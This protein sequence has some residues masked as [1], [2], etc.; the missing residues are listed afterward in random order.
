[1]SAK[2]SVAL[3][4]SL[5][6]LALSLAACRDRATPEPTPVPPTPTATP[7]PPTPTPTPI[8]LSTLIEAAYASLA[9]SDFAGASAQFEQIAADNPDYA[10]AIVGL[11]TAYAVQAGQEPRALEL[12]QRAV[13]LAPD[14]PEAHVAL[15]TAQRHMRNGPAALQAAQ[16]AAQIAPDSAAAQAE[17]SRALLLDNQY[18]AALAAAQRALEL[19]DDLPAV[20]DALSTYYWV[21]GDAARAQAALEKGLALQ[22]DSVVWRLGLGDL[23]S[24]LGRP[25]QAQAVYDEAL[26]LAPDFV[27]TLLGL[28]DLAISRGDY[29]AAEPILDQAMALA[30]DAPQPY[31]ARGWFYDA[32]QKSD[33]AR[34]YYRQAL[35]RRAGYPPA[36][37]QIGWT[38]LNENECDLAVRQFQ[39]LMADQPRSADGLVGMGFA[40]LC[41]GDPVKALEYLRKAV[42]LDPY[43]AWAHN[44]L[45]TAFLEQERWDEMRLAA[46]RALQVS[47]SDSARHRLLGQAYDM[48]GESDRAQAEWRIAISLSPGTAQNNSAY[49]NLAYEE[50]MAGRLEAAEE[51]A[52]TAVRLNPGNLFGRIV[53]GMTLVR[54]EKSAEAVD[55]LEALVEDEPEFAYAHYFLGLA[56]QAEGRFDQ[57]HNSL[58]TFL[59]L[60]SYGYGTQQVSKLVEGL[61]E[62]YFLT[63]N[64][65]TA[66]VVEDIAAKLELTAT[67][68]IV[69]LAE[70][71]ST[72]V[73]TVTSEPDQDPEDVVNELAGAAAAGALYLPRID[74][75]VDGGV[76]A[77]QVDGDA[78]QYTVDVD[79]QT[80]VD[81]ATGFIGAW[82]LVQQTVF[83]RVAPQAVETTVEEIKANVA[84]TREL[85]PTA[86]VPYQVL[87]EE[88]LRLRYESEIDDDERAGL[89]D[90]QAM[91]VLLGVIEPDVDLAQLYVD[92]GA[93]QIS[94]FY[95]LEERI[96]YLVDRGGTTTDDQLTLVHE[97]THALQDQHY[98][99]SGMDEQAANSDEQ[100][101]I[102][103]LVE[104]DAMLS[105]ALYADEYVS[106]FDMLQVLS[107]AAG[108]ESEVLDSSPLFIRGHRMFAYEHGEEFVSALHDRGGW[109]AVD[110]AYAKLPRSTE[111]ILHPERY[112]RGDDPVE[113]AL[114]DFAD[115]L[116]G[117]WQE[118]ER[119]VMGELAL[120]LFVQEH[121]G[122]S[123]A[124]LAAEGWGGDAYALLRNASQSS[125]LVVMQ[126]SWDNQKE[127]QEFWD[128]FQIAM[129]HRRD[130]DE[131]VTSLVGERDGIWWRSDA[132]MTY[133]RHD[134]DQVLIIAGPDQASIE[135]VLA[136]YQQALEQAA[137]SSS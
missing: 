68:Q 106:A 48:Q 101:A 17:L 88:E 27:G 123:L 87:N 20:Y 135:A 19:Q 7:V 92:L 110:A 13:A 133:A 122:P 25:E 116:G 38:Y 46:I 39:T 109:E 6:V 44:G 23:W 97:Y 81:F 93:E 51:L 120:R 35:D 83:T 2:R 98:D 9:R 47:V 71:G 102:R 69:D 1:M 96:F 127:A 65:A 84:A 99:L 112:R 125:Y 113:V 61:K 14:S 108:V 21:T 31:V 26:G 115:A 5:A 50:A 73:I 114:P 18:D 129:S 58:E 111:Q 4:V 29:A 41:D 40:R 105:M 64:E 45:A 131:V 89:A 126:T 90:D 74:P 121:A 132:A 53:L 79:H 22:P 34:S 130:Y 10:P 42:K 124:E 78:L 136:S 43:D 11:S 12:A 117:D 137:A 16:K 95:S 8:P 36:I 67:A 94:G 33:E 76:Q 30:P 63:E 3:A 119:E 107:E 37:D 104:G 59:D 82:E 70:L 24:E 134:G 28:A 72:L 62:G 80:A 103:A 15:S 75:A 60:E 54:A 57:A 77:R 49:A 91:L 56:Y 66:R 86:D 85:S 128:I 55:V 52:R 32:Q 100:L 118:V